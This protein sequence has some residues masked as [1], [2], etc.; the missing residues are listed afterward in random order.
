MATP[1]SV[2]TNMA[3]SASVEN[4]SAAQRSRD[5]VV[6]IIGAV[7]RP[8]V[9]G[10]GAGR[11]RA[12]T[13]PASPVCRSWLLDCFDTVDEARL[14]FV[15]QARLLVLLH[16]GGAERGDIG[17]ADGNAGRLE[18][19][20]GRLLVRERLLD[21]DLRG[22]ACGSAQ[23]L[24]LVGR[25]LV[26]GGLGDRRRPDGCTRCFV[27]TTCFVTSLNFQSRVMLI[28]LSWAS[29]APVLSAR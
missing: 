5:T 8:L 19:L 10:H 23:F 13:I 17:L 26:E 24:L 14:P 7:P 18:G 2:T 11:P 3:N 16:H 20:D 21:L 22:D 15:E 29:I 9:S 27:R 28:G 6:L 12:A 1:A 25:Q 4:H